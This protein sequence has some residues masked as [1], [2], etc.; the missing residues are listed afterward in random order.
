MKCYGKI[1]GVIAQSKNII[2]TKNQEVS[3]TIHFWLRNTATGIHTASQHHLKKVVVVHS[4][5]VKRLSPH[6]I[7]WIE[8]IL[9]N[10]YNSMEEGIK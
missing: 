1:R 2:K 10:D 9:L 6:V 7:F 8:S 4:E 3:G 5:K